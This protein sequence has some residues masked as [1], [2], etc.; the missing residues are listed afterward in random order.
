MLSVQAGVLYLS[1]KVVVLVHAIR[2]SRGIAPLML[3]LGNRWRT[4]GQVQA[5]V[6]ITLPG[7]ERRIFRRPASSLVTIFT[8]LSRLLFLPQSGT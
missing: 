1:V 3:N 4:S 2:G 7:I 8:E 6:A 5:P